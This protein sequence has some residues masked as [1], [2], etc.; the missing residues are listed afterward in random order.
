MCKAFTAT[1]YDSEL[2]KCK[3]KPGYQS[4]GTF[5]SNGVPV[6]QCTDIDECSLNPVI[7]GRGN[8]TN[9]DGFYKCNCPVDSIYDGVTCMRVVLVYSSIFK[10][11]SGLQSLKLYLIYAK[12][13]NKC[14]GPYAIEII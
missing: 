14:L 9:L 3:C 10:I 11:V 1:Q 13:F 2:E 6:D 8:C 7:C 5:M 12:N 4:S